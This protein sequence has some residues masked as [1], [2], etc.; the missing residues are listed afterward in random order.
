MLTL[1]VRLLDDKDLIIFNREEIRLM[2]I[3]QE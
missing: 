2:L 1:E 3:W